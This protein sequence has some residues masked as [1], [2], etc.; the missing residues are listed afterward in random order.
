MG[1]H[2]ADDGQLTLNS[3]SDSRALFQTQWDLVQ[4]PAYLQ[5]NLVQTP[6]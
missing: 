4:I 3:S 1:G 2:R 6:L 5:S